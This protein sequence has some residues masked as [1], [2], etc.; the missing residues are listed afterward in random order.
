MGAAD[1]LQKLGAGGRGAGDD[2][3]GGVRPVGGHLAATR[4]GVARSADALQEHLFGRHAE[5]EAE[6]A[7]AVIGVEPIVAGFERHTGGGLSG[8]M[9]GGTDLKVDAVLPLHED[10][11]VVDQAGAQ[12]VPVGLHELLAGE[13]ARAEV[14]LRRGRVGR[15]RS[16]RWLGGDRGGLHTLRFLS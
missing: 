4:R 14:A 6:G 10:F 1:G 7:V 11:A 12:H 13:V 8:F 3:L 9:T 5:G 15:E 2:V 16:E